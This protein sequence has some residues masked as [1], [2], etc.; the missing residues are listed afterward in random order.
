MFILIAIVLAALAWLLIKRMQHADPAV[1]RAALRWVIV[2]LGAAVVLR[3]AVVAPLPLR[4]ALLVFVLGALAVWLR[5]RGHGDDGGDDGRDPPVDPG[6]DPGA[7]HR[8][9]LPHERLDPDAFD[10]ARAAWE[11][12]QQQPA[13]D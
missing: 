12:Q 7:D 11:E 4:I 13:R 8:A 2:G 3:L 1:R 6:P 10:R 5:G 9:P